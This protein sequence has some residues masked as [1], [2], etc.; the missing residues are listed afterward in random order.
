MVEP[1]ADT[2]IDAHFLPML[3]AL[4]NAANNSGLTE[5]EREQ[6]DA[7]KAEFDTVC[8][9]NEAKAAVWAIEKALQTF[10]D[11]RITFDEAL[12]N[13][14]VKDFAPLLMKYGI[15][16]P[17][18]LSQYQEEIIAIKSAGTLGMSAIAQVKLYKKED[19]ALQDL[20]KEAA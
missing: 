13:E 2:E 11:K 17:S 18:F 20:N 15:L 9:E 16:L 6:A 10:I 3:S 19:L 7:K 14:A 12:K 1:W 8:V 4:K 5:S